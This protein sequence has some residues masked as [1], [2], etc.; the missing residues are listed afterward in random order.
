MRLDAFGRSEM[1]QEIRQCRRAGADP[2][3]VTN[4]ES[5]AWTV[6]RVFL[7]LSCTASFPLVSQDWPMWGG[8]AQR[9]LTSTMKGLPES[10][11]ARNGTNIKWKAPIGSSSNG[12]PVV[13]DGKVFLGTNNGNP[14]NPEITGDKGILMCFRESDGRFLWQA[15]TDKLD[16]ESDWPEEGVCSSPAVEG[17]RLYYVSNRGELICLDTEGFADGRNEGPFQDEVHKGPTDA[18]I[19]WK[20]DMRQELGVAQL[21]MA[22]SSPAV[23][24]DVVLVATSNGRDSGDE[25]VVAP[26]APSFLA[27]DKNTGK[28]VWLDS[29]PGE[30]I[31]HGQWSSPA[32]AVVDGIPQAIFPGGDGWLYSFNARTGERL[33]KFDLNPKDAVWPKTRN[34]GISSPVFSGGR[35]FISVGQDP[36]HP[37]GIGHTYCIN[38]TLRGDITDSGRVWQYDKIGRSIS[39]VAVADGLVFVADMKGFLHC[40]DARTGKPNWTFDMMAPVWGSPLVADGK[41]YLG[42]QDGDV[43]ILRAGTELKK[44][45]EIEMGNTV[46][47]TPVPANGVLYIMTRTDLY[48]IAP[49]A[50]TP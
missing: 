12:N 49:G 7:V 1:P 35:V 34:Y 32:L 30:G 46:Y 41:V 21:F 16:A 5:T 40:L 25:K 11:D 24:E 33:W 17:K 31:L 18:D 45:A 2:A 29:S 22:A 8:T 3:G 20:L 23:W 38:P 37:N 13:A 19:V 42:D 10:W 48:A 43:A 28:V 50:G 6:I 47:S 36:D 26:K 15:A 14:R 27:V 39:T 4:R 9:N 44:L